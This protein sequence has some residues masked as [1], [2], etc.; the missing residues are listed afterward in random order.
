MLG[1]LTPMKL[2]S[3]EKRQQNKGE[4]APTAYQIST[5]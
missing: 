4:A 5:Q 2:K 3:R 1:T